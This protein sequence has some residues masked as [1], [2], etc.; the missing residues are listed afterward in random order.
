MENLRRGE[1]EL[2]K[3]E[4]VPR[5]NTTSTGNRNQES[6]QGMTNMA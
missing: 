5:K 1:K 3:C 4:G 2:C 6:K